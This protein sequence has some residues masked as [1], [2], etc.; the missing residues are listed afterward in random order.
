M[1]VNKQ[2]ELKCVVT[3]LDGAAVSNT[4]INWF[5]NDQPVADNIIETNDAQSKSSTLIR[6]FNDW[7]KVNK[8]KCD[9]TR[10]NTAPI[11]KSLDVNRGMPSKFNG[12]YFES[13]KQT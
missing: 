13:K 11:T 1:F 2:A 3:G 7:K 8:V 4:K 9:A 6:N 5:I 10:E 12:L